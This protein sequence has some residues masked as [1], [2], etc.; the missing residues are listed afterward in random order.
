MGK[1][2]NTTVKNNILSKL[3]VLLINNG[4]DS[5]CEYLT[6][7]IKHSVKIISFQEIKDCDFDKF[8]LIVLS[9]GNSINVSKNIN[10]I[11][12]VLGTSVPVIGICYGFQLLCYAYGAKLVELPKK[13]EGMIN[14]IAKTR[15]P[16]FR[17]Q[18]DFIVSEKHRFGV[19][20]IPE[21]LVCLA[22]SID[23]CEFI[24][25]RNKNQFGLQFHPEKTTLQ[26]D[27]MKLFNN[28]IQY[29][30]SKSK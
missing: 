15:H 21:T 28:V 1:T 19:K 17:D 24:Q 16:I 6:L 13:R 4:S 30:F 14:I 20:N 23:G 7:L 8:Q 2:T 10:E 26:N 5:L 25:V 9:D 12:L 22:D 11:N 3:E 18:N 27:G 29:V